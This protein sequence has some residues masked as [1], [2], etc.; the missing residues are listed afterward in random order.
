MI[1]VYFCTAALM[2]HPDEQYKKGILFAIS[3]YAIWGTFPL[4]WKLLSHVSPLQILAHRIL[5]S[6][7]FLALVILFGRNQNFLPYVKT[8]K[9]L[10]ILSVS[11]LLIAANW[12]VYIYAVNNHQIVEASLGY[13]INP[14]VNVLLGIVFLKERLNRLQGTA[15]LFALCGLCYLTFTVG[16]LP[17]VSLLLAGTFSLY[18]LIRKKANLQSMPGLLIETMILV[19]I[20]IAYIFYTI[21]AGTT[22]Y[23]K[24][25]LQDDILLMIAGP[26]TAIPL[27]LFGMAAPKIPLSSIGFIQYLS[28]TIQLLIG[29]LLFKEPFTHANIISFTLV[30][31]GLAVYT[32]SVVVQ[33]RKNRKQVRQKER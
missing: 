20:A 21:R 15:L 13:Y 3:A 6:F 19:P 31:A 9:V 10:A 17:V 18:A 12:G 2:N 16:K 33:L 8:P 11:A 26:V 24:G 14:I 22:Y 4:Y 27:F 5:W 23:L 29:V 25:S 32:Y 30:W 7:V 1:F 28:P